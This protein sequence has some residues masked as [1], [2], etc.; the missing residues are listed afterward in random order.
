MIIYSLDIL[1]GLPKVPLLSVSLLPTFP[2]Q[3]ATV[4]D[5][6]HFLQYRSDHVPVASASWGEPSIYC[7]KMHAWQFWTVYSNYGKKSLKCGIAKSIKIKTFVSDR[8]AD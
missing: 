1:S 3:I 8:Q 2:N 7:C 5:E 6:L 4:Q